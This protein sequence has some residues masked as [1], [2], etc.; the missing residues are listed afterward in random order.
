[1]QSF[2]RCVTESELIKCACCLCIWS[3]C[4]C[5]SLRTHFPWYC[6]INR[7]WISSATPSQSQKPRS[8][9]PSTPFQCGQRRTCYRKRLDRA[10]RNTSSFFSTGYKSNQTT[11][12]WIELLHIHWK[13]TNT[14]VSENQM[15]EWVS[16][17]C[18]FFF[19]ST[20]FYVS[21]V[22]IY[23][24]MDSLPSSWNATKAMLK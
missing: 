14:H 23:V 13:H 20:L 4:Y 6:W 8:L 15:H 5:S 2:S 24:K 22:S 10:A 9:P 19:N 12:V 17:V 11:R 16:V 7:G 18:L 21:Y 1:M 3:G